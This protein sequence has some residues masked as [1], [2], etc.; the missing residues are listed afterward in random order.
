MRLQSHRPR[1]R[2]AKALSAPTL[3]TD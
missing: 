2:H 3:T 1:P